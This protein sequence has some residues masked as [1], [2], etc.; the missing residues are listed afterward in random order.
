MGVKHMNRSH[1][2]EDEIS[3]KEKDRT[4]FSKQVIRCVSFY[5]QEKNQTDTDL[6]LPTQV[7]SPF[8][9]MIISISL[10]FLCNLI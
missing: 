3:R 9:M 4:I 8:M 1:E 2:N 7:L 10:F 6:S 5:I